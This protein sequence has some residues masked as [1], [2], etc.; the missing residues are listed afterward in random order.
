MPAVVAWEPVTVR[1]PW[2]LA[3]P[4]F[5]AIEAL[6][7]V[8]FGLAVAHA[9]RHWRTTATLS[10]VLTLAGCFVYG[11]V[12]D[13]TA[14]YTVDSFRHG[15][16]SVMFLDGRLPLYI[17]LFYP[18][19]LYATVMTIRRFELPPVVE[20][21]SCGFYS[22]VTYLAF[23]NLGPLLGWWT[24]DTADPLNQPLLDSVPLT[25]YQWFFFFT[26]AF[27]LVARRLCWDRAPRLTP[28]R[29]WVEVLAIPVL[30][31]ALGAVVF[32]PFN[33]L[34]AVEA[35][36]LDVFVYAVLFTAA[37][38]TFLLNLRRVR[39][40]RDPLL[41]VFPLL[42]IVGLLYITVATFSRTYGAGAEGLAES[43]RPVGNLVAVV[44]AVVA[45]VAMT[46]CA[47][48]LPEA[49]AGTPTKPLSRDGAGSVDG[50]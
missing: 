23:D 26:A 16:F 15:E 37:G 18:A 40:P 6:V 38:F 35:Y 36:T 43:G 20:A 50:H 47:H 45:S 29:A 17:A 4:T 14:Y 48:P 46:L 28:R 42:W 27:T 2:E 22:G 9:L 21:V 24:W 19:F 33:I 31:Y 8:G 3:D 44:V 32:I 1:R 10:A 11:L 41:M 7:L 25:S 49:R 39:Q 30:T 34:A 12:V 13:I 5:F